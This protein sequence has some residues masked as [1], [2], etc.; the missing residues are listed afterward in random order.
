VQ[1]R[2]TSMLMSWQCPQGHSFEHKGSTRRVECPECGRLAD[3][4]VTYLCPRDGE[5][6]ALIRLTRDRDGREKV[7]EISFRRGVWRA[8]GRDVRCPQCGLTMVPKTPDPFAAPESSTE[9]GR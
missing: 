8:V 6:S 1:R 3:V 5:R 2:V 4:A 7:S 9:K